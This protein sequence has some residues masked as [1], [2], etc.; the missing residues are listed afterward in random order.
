MNEEQKPQ[1]HVVR[2]E[3]TVRAENTHATGHEQFVEAQS[4]QDAWEMISVI[5]PGEFALF[6]GWDL[7]FAEQSKKVLR[8]E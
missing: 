1:W 7:A 8:D 3:P 6:V 4:L 2:R 5:E